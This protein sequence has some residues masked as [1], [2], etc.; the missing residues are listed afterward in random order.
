MKKLLL[1]LVTTFLPIVA[2]ASSDGVW[3]DGLYYDLN[4]VD[5][6]A[7]L[8]YLEI[9]GRKSSYYSGRVVIPRE[10]T[11]DGVKFIV[12][13]I[14]KNAFS[15][16]KTLSSVTIPNSVTDIGDKAFKGCSALTSVNIPNSV[17][18][19]GVAA[20]YGCMGLM[21]SF[22][23]P[24]SVTSIGSSAFEDCVGLSSI[25][26]SNSVTTIEGWTFHGCRNLTSVTIPN[27][28]SNIGEHAFNGC[29]NLIS[30][31]S[32]IE[33][34]F[35]IEGKESGLKTFTEG[36]FNNAVLYV[37][38]GTKDKYMNTRGWKDFTHIMELEAE[39]T[40]FNQVEVTSATDSDWYSL[41]GKKL[42]GV[43]SDKG[44]YIVNGKKVIAK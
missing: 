19:I 38:V 31:F 13:S 37:P 18:C 35:G 34:P 22:I 11:L 14:G 4:P 32:L 6:T 30:I 7:T 9:N 26:I 25:S 1:F 8:T 3:I 36:V 10:I 20:F 29:N 23:I 40:S 17:T 24:N 39:N 5:H 12:N 15:D 41:N 28:V 2:T 33:E 27:S 16:S 21:G 42:N 43:P 44:V